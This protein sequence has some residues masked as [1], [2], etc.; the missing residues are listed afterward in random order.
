[1]GTTIAITGATGHLASSIIPLLIRQGYKIRALQYEQALSFDEHKMEMISGSILDPLALT[2]LV[3]GCEMVIH[4]AA[5]ISINSNKDTTLYAVNVNGTKNL[6]AAAQRAN[7]KRFIYIS[8]I[9][10]Y[11]Q[12]PVYEMLDETQAYCD[13]RSPR[14][15]QSKRDAQQYVL[16]HLSGPMEVVVLNPTSVIGPY[17]NKPSLLGKAVMDMYTGKIPALINGGFDFCDVRDVAQGIVNALDRGRH[18]HAYLLAG[19]WYSVVDLYQMVMDIKGAPASIPVLPPWAGYMGL[20]F[21]KMMASLQKTAPLYTKESLD[22]LK[23]GNRY[24]NSRK[25]AQE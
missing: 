3:E 25:A 10:A 11:S 2:S 12:F 14:Y 7:V 22:A 20:P 21:I 15:D 17:D 16:Q 18:G 13:H 9:H 23:N 6:L 4:A 1:M 19:K 5:K 8:S 24:I